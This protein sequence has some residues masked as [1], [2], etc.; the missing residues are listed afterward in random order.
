MG[1]LTLSQH[2]CPEM[3]NQHNLIICSRGG[4]KSTV[5]KGA[6]KQFFTIRL[7]NDQ[8]LVEELQGVYD[9]LP[10]EIQAELPLKNTWI[11]V[12]DDQ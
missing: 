12:E 4:F 1:P 7:W 2:R 9:Q 6:R 8:K 5:E 10:K 3:E 11:L